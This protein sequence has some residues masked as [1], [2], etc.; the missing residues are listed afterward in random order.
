[1]CHRA[2]RFRRCDYGD[3]VHIVG[4]SLGTRRPTSYRRD[5]ASHCPWEPASTY[6]ST[7]LDDVQK[8]QFGVRRRLAD[9]GQIEE[10]L[11][12]VA[13]HGELVI[14]VAD[15]RRLDHVDIPAEVFG[16]RA[17]AELL[18]RCVRWK[19]VDVGHVGRI[20]LAQVGHQAAQ[21]G[22]MGRARLVDNEVIIERRVFADAIDQRVELRFLRRVVQRFGAIRPC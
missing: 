1:M 2:G 10:V 15:Q 9:H 12:H 8:R 14:V 13:V 17:D 18:L 19:E 4:D 6:T 3:T 22:K 20:T 7:R 5:I 11:V 21:D 16:V